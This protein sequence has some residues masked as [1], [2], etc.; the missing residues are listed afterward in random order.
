MIF[1]NYT[2]TTDGPCYRTLVAARIQTM[3]NRHWWQFVRGKEFGPRS[4]QETED[5][6]IMHI[7]AKY[8]NEA[9]QALERLDMIKDDCSEHVL[10]TLER[11]WK[12]IFEICKSAM[13]GRMSDRAGNFLSGN[14]LS[15]MEF[16]EW[17]SQLLKAVGLS[18]PKSWVYSERFS[19]W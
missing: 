15:T 3:E 18:D 1:S 17:G 7:T 9:L 6:I 13:Q 14:I 10:L 19:D 11:R 16:D 12:Q 8:A 4:D 5:W 2:L